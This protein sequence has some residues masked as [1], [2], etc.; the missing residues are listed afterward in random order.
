[1]ELDSGDGQLN[2][3]FSCQQEALHSVPGESGLKD[4]LLLDSMDIIRRTA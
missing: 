1:M 2:T 4:R 3:N